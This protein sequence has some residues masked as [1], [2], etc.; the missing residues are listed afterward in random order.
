MNTKLNLNKVKENETNSTPFEPGHPFTVEDATVD[1]TTLRTH[2]ENTYEIDPS[3]VEA[4]SENIGRLGLIQPLYVREVADGGLQLLSGHRRR[5]ALLKLLKE[6]EKWRMVPVRIAKGMSDVDALFILHSANIFRP[7]T[8]DDRIKQSKELEEE[9]RRLK[10]FHPEWNGL[11]THQIVANML[12]MTAGSYRRKVRLSSSLIPEL[13]D[14]YEHDLLTTRNAEELVTQSKEY[15]KEFLE[16]LNIKKPKTKKETS[17]LYESFKKPLTDYI[18]A[19]DKAVVALD[20]A[21]FELVDAIN[22]SDHPTLIELDRVISVRDK[23][24]RFINKTSEGQGL[25][26][27]EIAVKVGKEYKAGASIKQ[28]AEE[29]G[30]TPAYVKKLLTLSQTPLRTRGRPAKSIND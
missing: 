25:S 16:V 19:F 30:Y 1:I 26:E 6:D 5:A 3:Q 29:H 24:N 21:Y 15:Q 18:K 2:P 23:L 4:L 20:Y 14:M 22:K 11:K 8:Q 17:T 12:G 27:K 28:L 13:Y 10:Q 7:L 9:V